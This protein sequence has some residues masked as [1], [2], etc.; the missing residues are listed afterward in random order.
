[1]DC[2]LINTLRFNN[3]VDDCFPNEIKMVIISDF[4]INSFL[5]NEKYKPI[6]LISSFSDI[7]EVRFSKKLF[8]KIIFSINNLFI[9]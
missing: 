9:L 2:V 6:F 5:I 4:L 8:K 1:M 3:N 7:C